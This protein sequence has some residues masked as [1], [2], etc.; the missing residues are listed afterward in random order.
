[1]C[2][3]RKLCKHNIIII[4]TEIYVRRDMANNHEQL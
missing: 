4:T 3:A 2:Q 1:M